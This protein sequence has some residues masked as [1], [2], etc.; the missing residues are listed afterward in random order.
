MSVNFSE[1]SDRGRGLWGLVPVKSLEQANH[2]L[3]PCL[4]SDRI[5]F[6][7]SMYVDVMRALQESTKIKN[8]AIVTADPRVIG[9]AENHD[10]LVVDE[11]QAMGLNPAIELGIEAI[12]RRGGQRIVIMPTDI[13][14]V[15]GVEID[16]IL[17]EFNS[18]LEQGPGNFLGICP[19]KNSDGT[20]LL[21]L[22]TDHLIRLSYGPDSYNL[23]VKM[24]QETNQNVVT[25]HSIPISIDIDDPQDLN[26]FIEYC[27]AHPQYQRTA[28]WQFLRQ[29]GHVNE[30]GQ[31]RV[32]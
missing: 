22:E 24:A 9:I 3:K 16:R 29:S 18:V 12:R 4:G 8:I 5:E 17:Q 19:A 21:C 26:E 6:S 31:R 11:I 10:L 7:M 23:H 15:T 25:L 2:R 13:P 32:G 20:N 27:R 30:S 14:L 28:T 1:H